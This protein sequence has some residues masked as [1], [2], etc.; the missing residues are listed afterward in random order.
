MRPKQAWTDVARFAREGVVAV[1]FG[2]GLTSQ[3]H[4]PHEYA[5]LPLLSESY[6]RLAAFLQNTV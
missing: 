4:Q 2:P 3:A 5:E 6:E 1:N